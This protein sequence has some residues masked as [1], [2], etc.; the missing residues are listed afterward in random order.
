MRA[1]VSRN[2]FAVA[3]VIIVVGHGCDSSGE[4]SDGGVPPH[5]VFRY[6]WLVGKVMHGT[7]NLL[8]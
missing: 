5:E 6:V 2:G 7:S 3:A 1:E 8:D 4:Y